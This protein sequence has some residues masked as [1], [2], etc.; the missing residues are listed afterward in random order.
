MYGIKPSFSAHQTRFHA[1]Q[2]LFLID[3]CSAALDFAVPQMVN[4]GRQKSV[5]PVY[6]EMTQA[7]HKISIFM[8]PAF[9]SI[10]ESIDGDKITSPDTQV[11]T[12]NAAPLETLFYPE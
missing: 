4:L 9:K 12:A 11:A 2:Y 10:I 5:F 8:A 7:Q 6:A 3:G 1:F